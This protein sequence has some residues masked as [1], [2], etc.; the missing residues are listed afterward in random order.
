MTKTFYCGEYTFKG[1]FVKAGAGW[2]IGY[3]FNN[4]N[5]FVSNFIDQAEAKQWWALSQKHV[6][7]FCKT[8]FYPNMNKAFFGSFVGNYLYTHYYSFLK[9]VISKNYSYSA[10]VYKKDFATYKKFKSNYYAA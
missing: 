9:S 4:K 8:E 5:Y 10:K 7:T 2:E 1:Y 6:A 3:K